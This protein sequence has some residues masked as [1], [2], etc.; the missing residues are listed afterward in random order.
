MKADSWSY[1]SAHMNK[2]A[3]VS[4]AAAAMA[5]LQD[6]AIEIAAAGLLAVVAFEAI[7]YAM[8]SNRIAAQ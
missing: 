4:G 3:I 8:R 2:K 7:Q 5:F 1:W 6:H